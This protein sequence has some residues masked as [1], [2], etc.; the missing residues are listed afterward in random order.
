MPS[1][2]R[3]SKDKSNWER[4]SQKMSNVSYID[5]FDLFRSK[6]ECYYYKTDT[7]WNDQGASIA[8]DTI[9]NKIN[10]IYQLN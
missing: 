9:I 5:A 10:N 4:L 3:K 2:Y 1:N 7:H 6:K 8:F